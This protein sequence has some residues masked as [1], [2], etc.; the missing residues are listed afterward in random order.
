VSS[1]VDGEA[2]GYDED[3]RGDGGQGQ[4]PQVHETCRQNYFL[5]GCIENYNC[6]INLTVKN[7]LL[8]FYIELSVKNSI[9]DIRTK[10]NWT[11]A[12][13]IRQGCITQQK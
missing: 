4:A 10:S 7:L 1:K 8:L 5:T 3:V 9:L 6:L 13:S 11:L 12:L 2:D